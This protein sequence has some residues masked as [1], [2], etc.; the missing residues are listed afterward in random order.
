ML[1]FA[2]SVRDFVDEASNERI[3]WA[4]ARELALRPRTVHDRLGGAIADR[5]LILCRETDNDDLP[6]I[7]HEWSAR[8]RGVSECWVFQQEVEQACAAVNGPDF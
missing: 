1:D 8:P 7:Y 2:H 5:L 4:E 6:P 3:D